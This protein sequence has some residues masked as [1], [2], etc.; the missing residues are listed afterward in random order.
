[1][2]SVLTPTLE[3]RKAHGNAMAAKDMDVLYGEIANAE[4]LNNLI[5]INTYDM[6]MRTVNELAKKLET[7]DGLVIAS[8]VY[9]ASPNGALIA[10]LDRL[11]YSYHG[12]LVGKAAA[13]VA[14]ARRGG[15]T[16]TF[17]VLNKY[18]TYGGMSVATGQYWN[19]LHGKGYDEAQQDLE[20]L[21]Q[22]RTLATNMVF[23][24]KSLAL[25]KEKYGLPEHEAILR[26][27]FVR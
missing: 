19:G 2:K 25:G 13:S 15:V 1:M 22:M 10:V 6:S 4:H 8:P 11:F 23:L 3:Q 20:G 18:I 9:Y 17:D 24:M 12:P 27:N 16:T 21:Q 26:T 7:A 14:V 5:G